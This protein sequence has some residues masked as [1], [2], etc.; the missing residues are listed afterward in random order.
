[1]S[2]SEK[3]DRL[4]EGFSEREYAEPE[5]YAARR[6]QIFLDLGPRLGPGATVVDLGCGD[7][8]TAGPLLE[9]GL[10]YI[11]VDASPRMVEVAARRHP[12]IE[13]VVAR[14]EEYEPAEPVDSTLCLRALYLVDDHVAF[15]RRMAGYTKVKVVFDFRQVEHSIA[16]IRDECR[17]AGFS[18]I[19][20]RAFFTPQRH[21]LPGVAH[22]LLELLERTGPLA[23]LLTK[24]F[25]RVF[26]SASP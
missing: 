15:L 13:L 22:R 3:Y 12:G 6:A 11:G 14:Q 17:A 26:C 5:L 21:A 10:R 25:G 2:L 4:A 8:I 16:S 20:F 9:A 7:G 23:L 1:M 18:H 24:R 19:E